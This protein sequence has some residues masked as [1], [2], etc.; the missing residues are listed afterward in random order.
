MFCTVHFLGFSPT[1]PKE[2]E[3]N[4]CTCAFAVA[5]SFQTKTNHRSLCCLKLHISSPSCHLGFFIFRQV[6]D[7]GLSSLGWLR[8]GQLWLGSLLT[9]LICPFC[10]VLCVTMIYSM[11][12]QCWD[13][14]HVQ[15]PC[16]TSINLAV[17]QQCPLAHGFPAVHLWV[18]S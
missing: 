1:S 9:L 12:V 15:Q 10:L 2:A 13:G 5:L 16:G 6:V 18:P 3:G 11:V 7:L 4:V 14:E 8:D 17:G